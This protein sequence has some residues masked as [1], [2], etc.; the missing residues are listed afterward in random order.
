M[1]TV[2]SKVLSSIQWSLERTCLR[3]AAV[4]AA[5]ERREGRPSGVEGGPSSVV[6]RLEAVTG[7]GW[8]GGLVACVCVSSTGMKFT[9]T[10]L[11]RVLSFPLFPEA[12]SALALIAEV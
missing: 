5:S 9:P 7:G 1:N 2:Y 6:Q 11:L 10:L 8:A 12:L 4:G 3:L